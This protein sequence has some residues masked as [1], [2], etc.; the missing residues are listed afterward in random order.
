MVTAERDRLA[1]TGAADPE[2]LAAPNAAIA[3]LDEKISASGLRGSVTRSASSEPGPRRVRSDGTPVDLSPY[4][5]RRA[6]R[7]TPERGNGRE[8]TELAGSRQWPV[9][10]LLTSAPIS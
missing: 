1:A 7:D 2:Q 10:V 9:R 3:A 8:A 4:D 6:A 5:Y